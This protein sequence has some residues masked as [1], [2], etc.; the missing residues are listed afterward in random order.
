MNWGAGSRYAARGASVPRHDRARLHGAHPSDPQ[1]PAPCRAAG[2]AGVLPACRPRRPPAGRRRLV[3]GLDAGLLL[4]F[5]VTCLSRACP[6][7]RVVLLGWVL[8]GLAVHAVIDGSAGSAGCS[9][10]GCR[11]SPCCSPTTPAAGWPT[12]WARRCTSP[13]RRRSTGGW[14]P[15]RCPRSSCRRTGTRPGGKPS[16][17][18]ST[19]ATSSSR[20]C[21]SPCS[22]CATGRSG[23]GSPGGSSPS[24]PRDWSPMRSIRRRRRGWRPRTA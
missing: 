10:T 5:V 1:P 11:W 13:S 4:S 21:S 22:G 24:P 18:S 9:P 12:G 14:A 17:P 2:R 6:T 20:R 15:V 16:R 7:D 23:A 8:A 19:A 3:R